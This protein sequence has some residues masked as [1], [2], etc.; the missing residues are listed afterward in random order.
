MSAF[1]TVILRFVFLIILVVHYVL[2]NNNENGKGI[3][4]YLLG[5]PFPLPPDGTGIT[6]YM[7]FEGANYTLFQDAYS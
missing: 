6:K 2:L 5:E 7:S 3:G 1:I 4:W